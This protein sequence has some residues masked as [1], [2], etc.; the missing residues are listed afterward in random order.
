MAYSNYVEQTWQDLNASY[1]VSAA[2]MVF[3]EDGVFNA[4]FQPAARVFHNAAQSLTSGAATILAFNSER[5]DQ[6][7]GAASTMHDTVTNTSRLTCR[8]AG[9]YSIVCN[10]EWVANTAGTRT[11]TLRLN[12]TTNIGVTSAQS[13][14]SATFRQSVA[15]I[16]SL[17]VN[18]YV[19]VQAT[20]DSGGPLSVNSTG[21]Y[22]PEFMWVRVG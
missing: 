10:V 14:T 17:S 3:I 15:T 19:E 8:Y 5:F 18:D 2:R 20:Q 11:L 1:P 16:Y 4:H 21:N 12:N 6:A 22:S 7:G 13:P 9:I